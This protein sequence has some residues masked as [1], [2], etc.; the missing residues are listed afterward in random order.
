MKRE[1]SMRMRDFPKSIEHGKQ[2]EERFKE[3]A[4]KRGFTVS[5]ADMQGQKFGRYDFIIEKGGNTYKVDVKAPKAIK[6]GGGWQFNKIWVEFQNPEGFPGTLYSGECD[7][8]AFSVKNGFILV[9]KA[10]LIAFCEEKVSEQYVRHSSDALY[11]KYT[12]KKWGRNDI[13]SMV[14]LDDIVA[15]CKTSKWKCEWMV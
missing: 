2:F 8:Y 10:D 7:F 4:V 11:K 9:D 13:I 3:A 12:R 14:L 6:R 1:G 5:E 15:N